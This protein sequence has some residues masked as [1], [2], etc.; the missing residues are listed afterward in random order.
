MEIIAN[1]LGIAAVVFFVLSYQFKKN[2]NII[3][4][5][6]LSR[7]LYVSQYFLLGA[8]EGAWLDITA[9][10]ISVFCY[11]QSRKNAR[12]NLVVLIVL[13]NLMIVAVGLISYRNIFS[14]LPILGVVFETQAL[15]LKSVNKILLM[16]LFGAPFW[17]I[18]NFASEAYGSC[19]GDVLSMVSIGIAMIRYDVLPKFKK[20]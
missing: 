15:Y 19:I 10:L 9:F 11:L 16:S 14:I 4:C 3:L 8:Y 5:N 13:S 2:S 1:I 18:Y 12:K 6:A 17:L 7:V 20:N